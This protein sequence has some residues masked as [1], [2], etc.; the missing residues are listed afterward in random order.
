MSADG[1]GSLARERTTL[2]I[3]LTSIAAFVLGLLL[4]I[5]SATSGLGLGFLSFFSGEGFRSLGTSLGSLLIASVAIT[6]LLELGGRRAFADE[7]LFKIRLSDQVLTAGITGF[8][9][10]L[11]ALDWKSMFQTARELDIFFTYGQTWRHAYENELAALAKRRHARIRVVLP[12]P[13]DAITV[14]ALRQRLDTTAGDVRRLIHAAAADFRQMRTEAA[15][16]GAEV[17]LWYVRG[18]PMFSFYRFDHTIILS[19]N[20]HR[21]Q[22]LPAIPALILNEGGQLFTFIRDEFDAITGDDGGLSR[23]DRGDMP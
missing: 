7:L 18:E 20:S 3:L 11:Y 13:D 16:N 4:M 12:D 6:I 15:R 8:T 21:H 17:R 5:I 22:R 19:M 14:D 9:T 2:R 23:M 10:T 1:R